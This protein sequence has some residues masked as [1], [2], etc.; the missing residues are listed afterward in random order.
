MIVRR[1]SDRVQLITQPDHAHLARRIMERAVSLDDRPRRES[2]LLAVAEHD[3]GWAEEDA[4]PTIDFATGTVV[5]FVTAP[6]VVRHRVWPRAIGR[7][8]YDPWAAALVA[9]HAL[10]VYDRYRSDPAW[11]AF[12]ADLTELRDAMLGASRGS[13]EDLTS[14]Y[15]FVRLGDLI[16]LTFCSGWTEPQHFAGWI[17]QGSGSRVSVT[18]SPFSSTLPFEVP[19]RELAGTSF[20]SDAELRDAFLAA[21]KMALAGVVA[22]EGS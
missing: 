2:I 4:L 7:L 14:D 9:E 19:S 20:R 10:T 18:P 22:G 5:D 17:V 1:L 21:P 15:A 13:A 3:D 11:S 8:S 12:F 6:L 16:S